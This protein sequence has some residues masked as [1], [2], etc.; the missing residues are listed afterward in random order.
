MEQ[1]VII[2]GLGGVGKSTFITYCTEYCQ[3]NHPDTIVKELST[4]DFVKKIAQQCGW[5]GGKENADRVFLSDLKIAMTK[6]DN[7]PIKDVFKSIDSEQLKTPNCSHIFFV[8][9]REPLDIEEIYRI[10]YE[11]DV[12]IMKILVKNPHSVVNEVAALI[13]GITSIP[14][15]KV[16][17][18]D[19]NLDDL[20][21][22]A[23]EF[24]EEILK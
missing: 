21:G 18:N 11:R 8:N 24:V 2:N 4:V 16:I 6:W 10:A 20:K 5:K 3:E 22:K 1:I 15:D 14:Y 17:L 12:P 13:D 23:G 19:R 7:I 9:S